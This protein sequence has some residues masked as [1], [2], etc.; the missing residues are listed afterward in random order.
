[1]KMKTLKTAEQKYVILDSDMYTEAEIDNLAYQGYIHLSSDDVWRV[2][3]SGCDS[4]S[5]KYS[6][7]HG[8]YTTVAKWI[9]GTEL[10]VILC[11]SMTNK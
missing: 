2:S 10:Y 1:M 8:S 4:I 9:D 3:L 6:A 7:A 5:V 11:V